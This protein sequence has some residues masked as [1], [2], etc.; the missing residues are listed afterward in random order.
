MIVRTE[1]LS[2]TYQSPDG[3]VEALDNITLGVEEGEFIS[4][5][6]PSG[7]GKSTLLS[8]I[9]GLERPTKG[10]VYLGD[11]L[12]IG[13][14][15][16]IG[17]MPQ[18]DQLFSWR[19]IWG[20]V[21]L[22]LEIQGKCDEEHLSYVRGLLSRYGLEEFVRST[23]D[24]LSGGMRQR[25]ALIRTLALDPKILLLDEPF[26]AL[27]Y[28]TRLG[29]SADIYSIIRS[30]GKTA[31]L[32]THDISESVSLSDRVIVLTKRPGKI[33]KIFELERL[34][35]LGPMERRLHRDFNHYFDQIWK[36]LDVNA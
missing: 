21:T 16:E 33:K 30:E 15:Q 24:Q 18:K 23:P 3:E 12:V 32:V 31:M 10:R 14:G 7:C 27:D 6:G 9:A 28:Q 19:T 29:V 34:R 17:Y 4:I 36:E 1:G 26:S 25:C 35:G 5:V 13:T 8:V 11:R 20:N 2:L 22:G